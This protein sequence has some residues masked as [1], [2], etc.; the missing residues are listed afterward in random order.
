M[1]C[2]S[3]I[4]RERIREL[5]E[6]KNSGIAKGFDLFRDGKKFVVFDTET[7]GFS[8]GKG[9][10]II[11]VAFHEYRVRN[12]CPEELRSLVSHVDPERSIPPRI[13]SLTR[14]TE[15]HVR[16]KPLIGDL[17]P[18]I[19]EFIGTNPVMGHNVCFDL[20]FLDPEM[21][22][23]GFVPLSRKRVL[24]T[25]RISRELYGGRSGHSLDRCARREGIDMF[26]SGSYHSASHD[27]KVTVEIFCSMMRKVSEDVQVADDE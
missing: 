5:R 3:D 8:H 6:R 12:G 1:N 10:R 24:D 16:G 20:R 4:D 18:E 11:E 7:T 17:V 15:E 25:L 2:G 14:I 23:A 9:D 26:S 22:A 21:E 27:A 13:T 19:I